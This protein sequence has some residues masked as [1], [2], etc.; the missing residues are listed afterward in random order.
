MEQRARAR[1]VFFMSSTFFLR[2]LAAFFFVFSFLAC[3][4]AR[5]Q[6][7]ER[8]RVEAA[9]EIMKTL[10]EIPENAIPP[11]LLR[12]AHGV[13]ILPGIL[14]GGFIIAARFGRGILLVHDAKRGW[15]DPVFVRLGGASLGFQ[16]GAQSTD[17]VLVLRTKRSVEGISRGQ[18]TFGADANVTAGPIGRHA[19]AAT[20]ITLKAEIYA[21]SRSRGVFAGISLKGGVMDIDHGADQAYYGKP[22]TPGEILAG[23]VY[24]RPE[25]RRLIAAIERAAR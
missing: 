15:S 25:A 6:S 11:S 3:E 20:D 21:Y 2:S 23:K 22:V 13:I 5:A 7:L 9:V 17:L 12:D 8:S 18:F 1:S 10:A 19:E 14:E 16:A 24:R 4:V